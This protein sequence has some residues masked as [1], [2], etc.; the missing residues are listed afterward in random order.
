M[1]SDLDRSATCSGKYYWNK[2]DGGI[3][4]YNLLRELATQD[5]PATPLPKQHRGKKSLIPLPPPDSGMAAHQRLPTFKGVGD[6]DMDRF[7]FVADSV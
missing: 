2:L 4:T 7:W 3:S 1:T 5:P 6:E